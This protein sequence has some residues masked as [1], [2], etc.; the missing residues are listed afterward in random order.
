[1]IPTCLNT[2]MTKSLE[3]I[4]P[5]ANSIVSSIFAIIMLGEGTLVGE[6]PIR[7]FWK[8]DFIGRLSLEMP[9]IIVEDFYGVKN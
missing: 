3:D 6:K 2:I 1:M 5:M 4:C 9:M 8:V 7:K